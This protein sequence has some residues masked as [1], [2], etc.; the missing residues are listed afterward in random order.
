MNRFFGGTFDSI[1]TTRQPRFA[2]TWYNADGPKLN[3]QLSD[4]LAHAEKVMETH[5][6]DDAFPNN[7]PAGQNI[8]A[9]AVPHAGYMF[10]GQTAAYAYERLKGRP[11]KRVFL[12]GP[13]HYRAFRGIA[14][15][16]QSTFATPLGNLR[17]DETVIKALAHFPY[18]HEN[19]EV[20]DQE[21][22][23]EM[24]LPLIRKVLGDVL[25]VPLAVGMLEN[26]QEVRMVASILKRYMH[27]G[28]IVIV[29][30][31]F[32]HYGPRF[33]YQP[34]TEEIPQNI[35]KLDQS[36]F[37]C[38]E[39]VDLEAFMQFRE[40]TN[41][42]ICGFYPCALLLAMLPSGC[43]ASLLKYET[44]QQVAFDP[45]QNSVSYLAIVFSSENAKAIWE[46]SDSAKSLTQL[47]DADGQALLRVARSS[48]EAHL[49]NEKPQ[50]DDLVTQE[51][52]SK[53]HEFRGAF[54]TLFLRN[55]DRQFKD[56]ADHQSGASSNDKGREEK[57]LRG[58]IGYIYP[59]K[60][61]LDAVAENAI[62]AATRDPRFS[63]LAESELKDLEIE[64]SVLTPPQPIASWK[65]IRLGVDGIV[66]HKH[67]QQAVFLPIVATEFGWDL[68]ETLR[69]LSIKANCG[70]NGWRDGASFDIFQAHAFGEP[71]QREEQR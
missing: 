62:S 68:P 22:S 16:A 10:S 38:L 14:L 67:G 11:V 1:N 65:D 18:F 27:A 51:Q 3:Q 33:E 63:P 8:L 32:T 35:K 41:D 43:H 64:V 56:S 46:T 2:G 49:R 60:A 45:E 61:L 71:G 53:F 70:P 44:S 50:F 37:D 34:F 40:K 6:I 17:L 13:S 31:D 9:V 55:H 69:Q 20:H 26:A 52:R 59:V 5:P 19:K 12:L 23:L 54:V 4:Y 24:Q 39:R 36:A 58:C 29:S 25:V 30:S 7:K 47:S 15:P 42:T 57:R 48:I 28:D 21:H 66:M